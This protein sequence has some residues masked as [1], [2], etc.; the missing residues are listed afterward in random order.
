M[1]GCWA[2][3]RHAS[4]KVLRPGNLNTEFTCFSSFLSQMRSWYPGPTVHYECTL[5]MQPYQNMYLKSPHTPKQPPQRN[6]LRHN[7]IISTRTSKFALPAPPAP[8]Y[9]TVKY[10]PLLHTQNSISRRFTLLTSTRS[11]LPSMYH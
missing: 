8:T 9:K 5:A 11:A 3:S 6:Q 10:L 7:P 4:G 2:T 1:P